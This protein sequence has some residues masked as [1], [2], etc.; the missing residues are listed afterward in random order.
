MQK[1]L[2]GVEQSMIVQQLAKKSK[3]EKRTHEYN[4]AVRNK[5]TA[6]HS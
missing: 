1:V 5:K 6:K 2:S 3:G 4:N